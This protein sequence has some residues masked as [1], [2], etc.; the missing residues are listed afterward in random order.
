MPSFGGEDA[1][2]F[3]CWLVI[4]EGQLIN[5]HLFEKPLMGN[6]INSDVPPIHWRKKCVRNLNKEFKILE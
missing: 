1:T 6:A 5:Q 4:P 2:S 3:D